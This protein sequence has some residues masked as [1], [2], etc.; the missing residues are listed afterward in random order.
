MRAQAL[1]LALVLP[2]PAMAGGYEGP[3]AYGREVPDC[4]AMA[5]RADVSSGGTCVLDGRVVRV[6]D[7]VQRGG[8]LYELLRDRPQVEYV[9]GRPCPYPT[10]SSDSALSGGSGYIIKNDSRAAI[11]CAF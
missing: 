5:V 4:A 3:G 10:R 11:G 9:H 6:R 8:I 7:G 1:A 2:V